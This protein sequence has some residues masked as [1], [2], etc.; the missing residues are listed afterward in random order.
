[1]KV[2]VAHVDVTILYG[3]VQLDELSQPGVY[4]KTLVLRFINA[5]I[6]VRRLGVGLK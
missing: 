5:E 3:F 6:I 4:I 1:M 2:A